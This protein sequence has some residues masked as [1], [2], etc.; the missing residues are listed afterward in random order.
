MRP[1]GRCSRR[2]ADGSGPKYAAGP[3]V[4]LTRTARSILIFR[5]RTGQCY[6]RFYRGLHRQEIGLS[7]ARGYIWFFWNMSRSAS[8][9]MAKLCSLSSCWSSSLARPALILS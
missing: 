3:T 2:P 6:L 5:R 7:Q 1:A 9:T 4:R 8:S